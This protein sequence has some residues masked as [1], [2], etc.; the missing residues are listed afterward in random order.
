MSAKVV[1]P[2]GEE[3]SND[4]P[5]FKLVGLGVV[6]ILVVF[7][8]LFSISPFTPKLVYTPSPTGH[9]RPPVQQGQ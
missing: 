8:I 6:T 9:V 7:T 4:W 5:T 2:K 1:T 3:D